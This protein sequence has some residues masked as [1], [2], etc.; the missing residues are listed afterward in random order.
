MIEETVPEETKKYLKGLQPEIIGMI[1]AKSKAG[2]LVLAEE[3]YAEFLK[4]GILR[5]NEISFAE[6]ET[7]LKEMVDQND[8]LKEIK[9]GKGI[10]HYYSPRSMV[11]SYAQLIVQRGID[12]GILMAEVVRENSERYPRPVP[13][14]LFGDSPFDLTREEIS[15]CLKGM[16]SLKEYQDIQQTITSAGRVFLYS[17]RHLAPDY[18]AML[19]EWVDVGQSTSPWDYTFPE[20]IAG[21]LID[22]ARSK[23]GLTRK[24]VKI[25]DHTIVYLKGGKGPTIL[26]LHGYTGN[27]DN[28]ILFAPYLTKDYHVVIPDIPGYG[29]SS[30][31]EKAPYDLSSQMSRLHKFTRAVDLKKFNMAGNSMGGFFAGIYRSLSRRNLKPRFI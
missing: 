31:L 19:A 27:K 20:K 8:D 25:D 10:S 11:E 6:F 12:P 2:R 14:D 1:R 29:E 26:L 18:A 30:K 21:Y 23:A 24:E 28:W 17:R 4:M 16:A 15:A 3:I 9:D 7:F 13:V 5:E 22:S